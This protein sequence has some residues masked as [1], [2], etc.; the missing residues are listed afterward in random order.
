MN[1]ARR[2]LAVAALFAAPS[3]LAETILHTERSLYRQ[4]V[5]YEDEDLVCMRFSKQ[6][7]A[8]QSCRSRTQPRRL[9][10][11]Y[12]RMMMGALYLDPAPSRILVMGLGGG[13]LVSALAAALP[14]ARIDAVEVDPAVV[15]V[16]RQYF[17]FAPGPQVEVHEEDGRVFVKRSLRGG[18]RYDL[19]MLDAYDHEYIPEH[20]LTQEFLEEVKQV[21]TPDGVV[22]ANTFSSSRLYDH[23]SATYAAV[24]G[25]FYNLRRN[26]RVILLRRS[27]LLPLDVLERNAARLQ[28]TL[29]PMG[30][31]STWLLA[32][33][34]TTQDWPADTRVL[35]DRYSPSNLLNA[36]GKP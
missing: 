16:A 8:R 36:T 19:V 25:R 15:R 2:R 7:T 1:R 34:V 6:Y 4:I 32:Q 29:A 33:F 31:D 28:D 5:V 14:Q 9:V 21:L 26:N 3:A 10:F 24:F 23:E 20:L 27:G 22:A 35:T 18:A 12:L 13:S 11:E 17:D 30:V